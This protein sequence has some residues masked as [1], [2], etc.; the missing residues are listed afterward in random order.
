M[1]TAIIIIA[2]FSIFSLICQNDAI[3]IGSG[4]F[5]SLAEIIGYKFN[6]FSHIYLAFLPCFIIF[7]YIFIHTSKNEE[8]IIVRYKDRFHYF[9]DKQL[10]IIKICVLYRL[11]EIGITIV[12]H[13]IAYFF[14]H[15]K[16]GYLDF[17]SEEFKQVFGIVQ[18][19]IANQLLFSILL[20]VFLLF[21]YLFFSELLIILDQRIHNSAA[22]LA[23]VI[24]VDIVL[25]MTTK[26]RFWIDDPYILSLLPNANTFL[27][28]MFG[29]QAF[30]FSRMLWAAVYWILLIGFTIYYAFHA[31]T[32]HDYIYT[33][34]NEDQT[35]L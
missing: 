34:E 18:A 28:F 1:G 8:F 16:S 31:F 30:S 33:A 25:L 14:A 12:I 3:E 21:L 29:N 2:V 19:N 27:E 17:L 11:S 13:G 23:I 32:K 7:A 22:V 10:N 4:V 24:G 6:V 5:P 9:K 26:A 15:S 35:I 20:Q